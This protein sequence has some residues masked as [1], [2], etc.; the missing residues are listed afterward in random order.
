MRQSRVIELQ[1]TGFLLPCTIQL[2]DFH[3]VP[4]QVKGPA[5]ETQTEFTL[6]MTAD[7]AISG[8]GRIDESDPRGQRD[9]AVLDF[10]PRH[11]AQ[12]SQS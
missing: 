10:G 9:V 4:S 3:Q 2:Q 6:P 1:D 5:T 7:V 12:E 8:L 11:V